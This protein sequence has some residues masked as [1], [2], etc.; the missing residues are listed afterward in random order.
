MIYGIYIEA[1][2]S[3]GLLPSL[4]LPAIDPLAVFE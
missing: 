3:S 4:D 2:E 1:R